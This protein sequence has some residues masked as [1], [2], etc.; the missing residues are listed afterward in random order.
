MGRL[1]MKRN[2]RREACVI[3]YI[4]MECNRIIRVYFKE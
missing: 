2:L 4:G 1:L 3:K